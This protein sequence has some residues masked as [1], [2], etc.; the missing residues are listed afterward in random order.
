MRCQYSQE[1]FP[2]ALIVTVNVSP[3]GVKTGVQVKAKIDTGAD[4]S[5]IP[6]NVRKHLRV[7]PGGAILCGGAFDVKLQTCSTFFITMCI[8]SCFSSDLE[9][10]STPD[11]YALI[12]RD[13]LNQIVLHANGPSG[14]FELTNETTSHKSE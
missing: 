9:V 4:I 7:A 2:S 6:E 13:M 3:I 1:L 12:G 8:D 14:F 11:E 10:I 5:A